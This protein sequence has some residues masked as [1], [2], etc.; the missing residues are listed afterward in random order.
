MKCER[1]GGYGKARAHKGE[2]Q[3]TNYV[4]PDCN[5]TGELAATDPSKEEWCSPERVVPAAEEPH[6]NE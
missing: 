5:G 3:P 6:T 4:C 2:P 1:C